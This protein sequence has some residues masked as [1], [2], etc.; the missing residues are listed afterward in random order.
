MA[1]ANTSLGLAFLLFMSVESLLFPRAVAQ[2][3][4]RS[5]DVV[6]MAWQYEKMRRMLGREN[7]FVGVC[8]AAYEHRTKNVLLHQNV[9]ARIPEIVVGPA[10]SCFMKVTHNLRRCVHP[11]VVAAPS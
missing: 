5:V 4:I 7:D 11:H 9:L 10:K 2:F 3:A 8:G 6:V 1:L